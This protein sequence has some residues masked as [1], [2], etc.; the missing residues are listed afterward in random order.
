MPSINFLRLENSRDLENEMLRK[1]ANNI[2]QS[3]SHR[4]DIF[5]ELFQNAIDAIEENPNITLGRIDFV[6]DAYTKCISIRDNGT[7]IEIEQFERIFQPNYSLKNG[8]GNLR[9]EKGVGLSFLVF[10]TT[11]LEI[12]TSN[13]CKKIDGKIE[14]AAN[15][16]RKEREESPLLDYS[17]LT[18]NKPTDSYTKFTLFGINDEEQTLWNFAATEL[19]YVLRTKTAVGNT[20]ILFGNKRLAKEIIIRFT[21]IDLHGHSEVKEIPY[22][23][24]APHEHIKCITFDT[25]K[26]KL[27]NAEQN[28]VTGRPIY[29]HGTSISASGREIRYYFFAASKSKYNEMSHKIL[30][31]EDKE[32][33][34]AKVYIAT[35]SMPTGIILEPPTGLGKVGYWNNI[36]I[37]LEYD[38]LKLD[39]GRKSVPASVG[40]M[41]K[42]VA[43]DI[44]KEV[45]K[46]L[47]DIVQDPNEDVEEMFENKAA[48][49]AEWERLRAVSNLNKTKIAFFKIPQTEQ[50]VIALFYELVGRGL[51]S[52]YRTWNINTVSQYDAFVT[53]EKKNKNPIKLIVEFKYE[54]YDIIADIIDNK[55]DYSQ[56]GMLICWS[57]N[58]KKIR[59]SNCS[60][61]EQESDEPH[62]L[63]GVTHTLK[64]SELTQPLPVICLQKFAENLE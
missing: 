47:S 28:S 23:F 52:G 41:L 12:E 61:E 2:L 60:I 4:W 39:M 64:V 18:E 10:S 5:S 57:L 40:T 29:G 51:L 42:K 27:A 33:V 17:L 24:D 34:Q 9:G 13:G 54:A 21:F 58:E 49:D 20:A 36:Y 26:E 45:T 7:G 38:D 63:H 8:K 15:W 46:H 30:G 37:V 48:I 50:G 53:Y 55:K 62:F 44:F 16:I 3:Y 19:E 35:K 22:R 31:K 14:Y 56:I 43:G 32:L 1:Q 6:Y 11:R 25:R 59:N